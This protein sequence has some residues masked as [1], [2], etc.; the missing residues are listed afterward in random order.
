MRLLT[1][2]NLA[3]VAARHGAAARG[4]PR[5]HA[6]RQSAADC[7]AAQ[8]LTYVD[9]ALRG[10]ED[11]TACCSLGRATAVS[12]IVS[13]A[14]SAG[15]VAQAARRACSAR[16]D[17]RRA[18]W[19]TA[20]P[21]TSATTSRAA[22]GRS[23]RG[24]ARGACGSRRRGR[25]GAEPRGAARA[26]RRGCAA[27]R[28]ERLAPLGRQARRRRRPV[29]ARVSARRAARRPRV[30]RRLAGRRRTA[31]AVARARRAALRRSR[32]GRRGSSASARSIA[33]ASCG[34]DAGFDE[35]RAAAAPRAAA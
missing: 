34:V 33:A 20:P 21:A 27:R 7:S 9:A 14:S 12:R 1:L 29:P 4:D 10:C 17:G 18:R 31:R 3:F 13:P 28:G 5:R 23:R 24:A 30:A 32:S 22:A 15:D 35:R 25:A 11:R 16:A 6:R 8:A 26:S 2:H 19:T